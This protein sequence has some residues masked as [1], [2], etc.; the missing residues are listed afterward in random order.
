[1]SVFSLALRATEEKAADMGS[2][3]EQFEALSDGQEPRMA[4]APASCCAAPAPP[5]AA[6]AP[7]T[8]CGCGASASLLDA[9]FL[10]DPSLG[11]EANAPGYAVFQGLPPPGAFWHAVV[12]ARC[13]AVVVLGHGERPA[14]ACMRAVC[15]CM[16][17]CWER[18]RDGG[19]RMRPPAWRNR[20][21]AA[22]AARPP[23]APH[24]CGTPPQT[25][26]M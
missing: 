15:A 1:M 6:P 22:V 14:C 10:Q 13:S 18:P 4:Q 12:M 24:A 2:W 7:I 5:S 23:A 19:P 11:P 17:P 26:A 21:C 25:N 16:R 3:H 8:C 9:S 20:A